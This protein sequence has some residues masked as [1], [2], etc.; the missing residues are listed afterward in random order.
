[1]HSKPHGSSGCEARGLNAARPVWRQSQRHAHGQRCQCSRP[2][3]RVCTRQPCKHCFKPVFAGTR[4]TGKH[5]WSA[6]P[7]SNAAQCLQRALAMLCSRCATVWHADDWVAGH[8]L[9]CGD[10]VR[11]GAAGQLARHRQQVPAARDALVATR[12]APPRAA[13]Q[14]AARQ[15]GTRCAVQHRLVVR[16]TAARWRC[17]R[18]CPPFGQ[19][20][21]P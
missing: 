12:A 14:A 16:S 2:A 9:R 3:D 7:G 21:A 19:M 17:P 11:A 18:A 1:M 4:V 10:P 13:R 6:C 5:S 15:A 8:S 20:H